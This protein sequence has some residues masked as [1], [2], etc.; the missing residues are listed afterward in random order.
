MT[1]RSGKYNRSS[2][3]WRVHFF[4]LKEEPLM[5]W[6]SCQAGL[7]WFANVS[8]QYGAVAII[9]CCIA[10]RSIF[11]QQHCTRAFEVILRLNEYDCYL[12]TGTDCFNAVWGSQEPWITSSTVYLFSSSC[13]STEHFVLYFVVCDSRE[14]VYS[15]L[16]PSEGDLILLY[17]LDYNHNNR[18]RKQRRELQS[19]PQAWLS[20]H[21]VCIILFDDIKRI[22]FQWQSKRNGSFSLQKWW[23][24]LEQRSGSQEDLRCSREYHSKS[25]CRSRK[26]W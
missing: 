15:L 7:A 8:L 9:W 25:S 13:K 12:T 20:S 21:V 18:I 2:S 1:S 26:G 10:C 23:Y 6:F 24:F 14:I 22:S 16:F 17:I 5:T 11:W 4:F 3:K 19:L